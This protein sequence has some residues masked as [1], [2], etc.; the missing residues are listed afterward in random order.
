MT[1]QAVENDRDKFPHID[2]AQAYERKSLVNTSKERLLKAKEEINSEAVKL[3]LLEDE[4]NKAIRRSGDGLLGARTDS[5]RQNTSFVLDNQAQTS[6]L[7]EQQDDTLDEL[8][9]AVDRV[10]EL[11]GNINDEIGMQNKM[12]EQMEEDMTNAE[13]ELGM[14][15]GKLAKFLK[16]KDRWQ[17]R[18]ILGL[19]L[20]AL[21]LFFLVLYS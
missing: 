8:G 19:T 20:T 13:E 12:L 4:R 15:M 6:L 9:E 3:K 1:V 5:E 11:A 17:L 18:T 2:D 14:V 7:M 10:G 21:I 16:T